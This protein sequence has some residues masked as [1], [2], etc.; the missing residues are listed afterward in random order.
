M[1]EHF[2]EDALKIEKIIKKVLE[3]DKY[4]HVER[5]GGLTNRTYKVTMENGKSYVVRLPGEGTEE[6]INRADEKN[7]TELA[8]EIGIDAQMLYFG[9]DG[10]KVTHYVEGAKTLSAKEL[11]Q[12]DIVVMVAQVLRM[13]HSSGKNTNVPFEVFDMA[14]SY[15]KIIK[16]NNVIL[17]EDYAQI[18]EKVMQVKAYVDR[19]GKAELVP[20]HND[21]LCEN[22]VL[23]SRKQLFLIDWEYAGMN[24]RMWDLA[25]VSIEAE[26]SSEQDELLLK[27]YLGYNPDQDEKEHFQANKIYIDFLWTLWGKARVPFDGESMEIYALERYERLKKNLENFIMEEK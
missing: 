25:D 19:K 5:L 6:L 17:Y 18:K 13:L 1:R 10:I 20:C 11:R 21:P 7:S 3:A 14:M 4:L 2:G 8:C 16:S 15:E 27:E 26:Y 24:D 12:R 23:S 22:W 9:E